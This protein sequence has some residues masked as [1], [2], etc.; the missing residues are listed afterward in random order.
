MRIIQR[1]VAPSE[2]EYH[3]VCRNCGTHFAFY[4]NSVKQKHDQREGAW[5][6][7]TCPHQP[8]SKVCTMT[9]LQPIES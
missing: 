3:Y 7:V 2:K 9:K 5:Y 4:L 1:G 8:C 6:E